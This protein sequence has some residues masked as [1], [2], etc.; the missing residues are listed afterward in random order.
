[1]KFIAMSDVSF[2][3][4]ETIIHPNVEGTARYKLSG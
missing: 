4:N 2:Q 3:T 1:M